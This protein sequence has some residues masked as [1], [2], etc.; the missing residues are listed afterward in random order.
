MTQ[1]NLE[2]FFKES[3]NVSSTFNSSLSS[4]SKS[5]NSLPKSTTVVNSPFI[6]KR[7]FSSIQ[8][9]EIETN[10]NV[11][12]TNAQG[13]ITSVSHFT[14][15]KRV[16]TSSTPTIVVNVLLEEIEEASNTFY[17]NQWKLKNSNIPHRSSSAEFHLHKSD[18]QS[19]HVIGQFNAGFILTSHKLSECLFLIDQ[20]A[21][22][23]KY[24]Y[25][26]LIANASAYS[27]RLLRCSP[28]MF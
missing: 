14:L 15:D 22:D 8:S 18:I 3:T 10:N 20:H 1:Y 17:Q 6:K 5:Q 9:T 27:Q 23:E 26:I 28:F 4:T 11:L 19:L 24:N 13:E 25:E 21:S 2:N 7:K 16:D 12:P